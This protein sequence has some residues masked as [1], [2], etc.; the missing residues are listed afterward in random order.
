MIKYASLSVNKDK[1]I[2]NI[3]ASLFVNKDMFL[4]LKRTSLKQ[5]TED[6]YHLNNNLILEII[7]TFFL[8]G[9]KRVNTTK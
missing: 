1:F 8:N 6:I 7:F 3:D 4:L 5:T 9:S 2:L